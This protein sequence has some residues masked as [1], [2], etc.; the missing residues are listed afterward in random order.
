MENENKMWESRDKRISFQSIF[1]S[2]CGSYQG[3]D[4]IVFSQLEDLAYAINGR[5]HEKYPAPTES[6]SFAQKLATTPNK[7][8]NSDNSEPCSKCGSP[9]K[10]KSGVKNGRQWSGSF[11]TNPN[12]K[13]VVWYP[14]QTRQQTVKSM[15]E[16]SNMEENN[17]RNYGQ[18]GEPN[19]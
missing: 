11:C 12:C 8:I 14:K 16:D 17:Q 6:T 3:K 1:S 7:A 19:F 13:H 15:T 2:L 18:Y 4:A 10:E 5:L 9:M